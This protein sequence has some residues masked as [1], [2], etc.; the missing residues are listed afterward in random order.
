MLHAHYARVIAQCT[1]N[2]YLVSSLA[3]DQAN[4]QLIIGMTKLIIHCSKVKAHAVG[5]FS[6]GCLQ[7]ALAH[8]WTKAEGGKRH[9]RWRLCS[10]VSGFLQP[11]AVC[12]K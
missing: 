11:I 8:L 3:E 5:Q 12:F 4:R 1:L 7:L 6:L 9:V 10:R 2:N